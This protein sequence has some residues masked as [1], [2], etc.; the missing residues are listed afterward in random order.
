MPNGSSCVSIRVSTSVA[1][2]PL[3]Q[4]FRIRQRAGLSAEADGRSD[5]DRLAGLADLTTFSDHSIAAYASAFAA[6]KWVS[7]GA[8]WV[9]TAAP[10]FHPF[11]FAC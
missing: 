6:W 1:S 10:P 7:Q 9:A 5:E 4:E 11:A 2:W 3:L 8:K